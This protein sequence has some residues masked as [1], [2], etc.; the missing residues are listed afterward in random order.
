[1]FAP[2]PASVADVAREIAA[3]RPHENSLK[4]LGDAAARYL[5]AG[6]ALPSTMWEETSPPVA[7]PRLEAYLAAVAVRLAA[8]AGVPPP[9]W[10]QAFEMPV[11][12]DRVMSWVPT[13]AAAFAAAGQRG[14][15]GLGPAPPR[16]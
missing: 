8:M 11:K 10:S 9:T 13:K 2:P 3:G 14:P 1:M 6:Q 16:R 15:G 12:L 5:A 7:D 4:E